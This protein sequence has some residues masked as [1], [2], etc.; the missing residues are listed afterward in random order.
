MRTTTS[1]GASGS[2][3]GLLWRADA[4]PGRRA[5]ADRLAAIAAP[6][7]IHFL[8]T[9]PEFPA[10]VSGGYCHGQSPRHPDQRLCRVAG[11]R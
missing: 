6:P 1:T 10:R 8:L 5:V 3:T 11:H 7:S 9:A 4:D 2:D